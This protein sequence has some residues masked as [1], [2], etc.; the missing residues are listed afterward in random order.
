LLNFQLCSHL[1]DHTV[2]H[3]DQIF[4]LFDVAGHF[5]LTF[6]IVYDGVLDLPHFTE[7]V[8][9]FF[10]RDFHLGC[11]TFLKTSSSTYL[12]MQFDDVGIDCG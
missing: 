6:M 10:A 4:L 11:R 1:F 2:V 3:R 12:T 7:K 8:L 9:T 5:V